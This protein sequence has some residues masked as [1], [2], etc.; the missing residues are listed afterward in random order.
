MLIGGPR[1]L[2]HLRG[3]EVLLGL[4]GGEHRQF[5]WPLS[6][7]YMGPLATLSCHL[8]GLTPLTPIAVQIS[9]ES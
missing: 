9:I 3:V 2:I 7:V 4:G 1:L 5:Q 8:Q 6:V